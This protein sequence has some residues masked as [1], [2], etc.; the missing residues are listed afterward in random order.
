MSPFPICRIIKGQCQKWI[1]LL[2]SLAENEPILAAC[3]KTPSRK[4]SA[5]KILV[6][7]HIFKATFI[8]NPIFEAVLFIAELL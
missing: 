7:F 8:I 2:T 3:V 5:S 6:F 4:T 1:W